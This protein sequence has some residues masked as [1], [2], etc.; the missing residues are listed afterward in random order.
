MNGSRLGIVEKNGRDDDPFLSVIAPP[1]GRPT[2]PCTRDDDNHQRRTEMLTLGR[3]EAGQKLCKRQ[4][5]K[6]Y[7]GRQLE[8]GMLLMLWLLRSDQTAENVGESGANSCHVAIGG[9]GGT[10]HRAP[11]C[12]SQSGT[13]GH[14]VKLC[15]NRTWQLWGRVEG[16]GCQGKGSE[17][18]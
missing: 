3:P 10:A 16:P 4:E 9:T 6:D 5:E 2:E 1:S 13:N 7:T 11:D 18:A 17:I 14:V 12:L 8:S 15:R